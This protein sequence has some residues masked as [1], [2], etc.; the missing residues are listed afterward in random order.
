MF[1][2]PDKNITN[3]GEIDR[4]KKL[5]TDNGG[6]VVPYPEVYSFQIQPERGYHQPNSFYTDFYDGPVFSSRWI[7][8]VVETQRIP[9]PFLYLVQQFPIY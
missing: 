6:L 9:D 2:I 5:I 8:A 3:E 4:I 7:E 1:F